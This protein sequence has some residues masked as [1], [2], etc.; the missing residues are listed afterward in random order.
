MKK[1]TKF[2]FSGGIGDSTYDWNKLLDGSIYQLEQGD[3]KDYECTTATFSTL[4]R[5]AAKKR[6]KT[7]KTE[8]T[9]SGIVIQAVE[10][11]AEQKK[12]WAEADAA[13]KAKKKAEKQAES[14]SAGDEADETTE[15]QTEE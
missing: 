5:S 15:E 12:E 14:E 3:G 6:G 7:L 4:A 10:A 11:T 2:E 9:E 1:L 13:R 8:K